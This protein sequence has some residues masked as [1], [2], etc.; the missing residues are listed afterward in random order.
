MQVGMCVGMHM[1]LRVGMR[2][3]MHMGMRVDMRVGMRAG[4]CVGMGVS[5]RAG[6]HVCWWADRHAGVWLGKQECGLVDVWMRG[7]GGGREVGMK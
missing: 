2:V 6:G 4:M 5:M 1:G 7:G 3:G